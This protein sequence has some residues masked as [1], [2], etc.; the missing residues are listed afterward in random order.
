MYDISRSELMLLGNEPN[1]ALE[2]LKEVMSEGYNKSDAFCVKVS[3]REEICKKLL[4]LSMI[5]LGKMYVY[6][7]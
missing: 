1:L 4:I 2:D 7:S 3:F 6:D 5:Y